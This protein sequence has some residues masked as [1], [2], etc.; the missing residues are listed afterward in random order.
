MAWS[1]FASECQQI[2]N[3]RSIYYNGCLPLIIADCVI[4]HWLDLSEFSPVISNLTL[5][6]LIVVSSSLNR[7]SSTIHST[8]KI[9]RLQD[10]SQNG[11]KM[12]ADY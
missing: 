12:T 8:T 11:L 10:Y 5:L 7:E 9:E 1:V 3:S 2:V 6:Y 4:V